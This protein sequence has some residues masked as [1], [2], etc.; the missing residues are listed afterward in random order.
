VLLIL[1][2]VSDSEDL[3]WDPWNLNVVFLGTADFIDPEPLFVNYYVLQ[4]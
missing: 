1:V 3:G 4:M 2:V